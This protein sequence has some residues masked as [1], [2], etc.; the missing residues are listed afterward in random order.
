MPT[1]YRDVVVGTDGSPT[2][3]CAVHAAAVVAKALGAR[4]TVATAWYRDMPDKPV[5]SELATF[6]G[7]DAGAMEASWAEHTVATAAAAARKLGA[8]DVAVATPMGQAAD[9]LVRLSEDRRDSLIVVGTVGLGSRTERLVGNVPN[10][11]A[12]HAPWDVLLVQT[13]DP[14]R[15]IAYRSVALATDGSKTATIAVERGLMVARGLAAEPVLLTVAPDEPSGR[16]V[17]EASAKLVPDA[18][19][20]PRRVAVGKH[21]AELLAAAARDF[22]LVVIGN[23]GMSGPSRLLGSVANHVTHAVPS[24]L[25]LVN[26][27]HLKQLRPRTRAAAAAD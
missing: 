24:D 23:K 25:L 12:H 15:E 19:A 13:S 1:V 5:L 6:P 21:V 4:L 14:E 8:P 16:R 11:V 9:V 7:G 22:D 2:A 18:D 17:L 27:M 26:T 10:Q 3:R 20:I